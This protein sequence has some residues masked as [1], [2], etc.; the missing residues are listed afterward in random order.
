SGPAPWRKHESEALGVFAYSGDEPARWAGVSALWL[1]G[2]WC[3]D[4]ASETIRVQS[5]DPAT[6]YITLAKK[7]GYGIGSGNPAPRRYRA[8]N[9]LEELDETG[10]Y[11]IDRA[12]TALYFWPPASLDGADIVL[13][14]LS[15][16]LLALKDVSHLQFSGL[17]LEGVAGTAMTVEGGSNVHIVGYTIR[18]A[19][20]LG[21]NI[22][23]GTKH[24]VESCDIHHNG[25]G[26]LTITGGDR[27]TLTPSGHRVVNNHI[28]RVSERMRT[29]AYNIVVGGVGVYMAHNEIND[30]PHQAIM[31]SGND[32]VFELNDIHH[33]ST[34]SDDCGAF[35]MGRNPSDRGTMIR[36][37]YWH[38]IG[39][40]MAHGSCAMYF[41]DGDG[42]QTVHGNVFYKASGGSFG[43]VFNHGGHNNVVTNNIF[44]ECGRALGAAPWNDVRWKKWL[45]E[46]LWQK[47]LLEEVDITKPPF[48]ERYPDLQGFFAYEG[49]RMNHASR[50]VAVG[51]K[52]FVNGNWD[53]DQSFITREDPGFV[54]RTNQNFA[55]RE[56]AAVFERIP[57]FEPIPFGKIGLYQDAYRTTLD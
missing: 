48:T 17:V 27:K 36:H 23:G 7:H 9:L 51:C 54:D 21:L 5:V 40:K 24:T 32:H 52:N 28:Y 34:D 45:N 33:I 13:S 26:G 19:G 22:K 57:G 35:Y 20:Q 50:N 56:D 16:P 39:S 53:I 1:E 8:V 46:P 2:Y 10:E 29:A 42:G 14:L 49:L 47:R 25:T 4:W 31:L 41:D 3:F 30:A 43:A 6:R 12:E 11:F 55:L 38:E 15:K 18:N 37:N 44:I